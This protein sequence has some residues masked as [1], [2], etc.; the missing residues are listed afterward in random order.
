M[1]FSRSRFI[2]TILITGLFFLTFGSGIYIYLAKFSA[3]EA[4][5]DL[6]ED[7]DNAFKRVKIKTIKRR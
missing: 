7:L 2:K 6:I 4:S 5:D 3:D 1:E